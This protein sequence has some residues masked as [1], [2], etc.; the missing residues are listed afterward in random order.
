MSTFDYTSRDYAS[1]QDDL[2]RRAQTLLPE[3]TN[4]EPSDFGMVLVDLWAYMGDILH[5]YVDRAAGESF[6]GTATQRESVL[7]I[8]NLLDYVPSGRRAATAT[9]TLNANATSATDTAP[10]YIP[11]YTRFLAT[12]LVDTASPVVFTTN[13]AIAFTG[14]AGG[15]STPLVDLDGVTYAT[16]PK[17]ESITTFLTEGEIFSETYTSTGLSGQQIT[18]RKTG[19][20]TDGMI[21]TVNEGAGGASVQ[22]TYVPRLLTATSSQRVFSVDISADNY[23]VLNF[24][25]A[26][27]GRIPLVNSTI[28]ITY[29]RSRG[30]AG[31]VASQAINRIESNT[32][33]GKPS[34]DGLVVT[35]NTLAATGGVD[36]ESINSLKANI[37]AAFRSQDRAVSL[38]DY[39]DIV[40]RVPGV[41]KST[42]W[43]DGSGVVQVRA[44]VPQSNFGA[45]NPII[46]SNAKV[47][48]IDDYLTPREMAFASSNVGASV[49]LSPVKLTANLRVMAGF[50]QEDVQSKVFSALEDL[51]SFDN[52][53]FDVT[54]GLGTVYRTALAIEGVD[55]FTVTNFTTTNGTTV[56]DASGTFIGVTPTAHTL[57]AK[58]ASWTINASGGIVATGG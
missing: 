7:A 44:V 25:N 40:K 31:N 30:A 55:Y 9:I 34:L 47:T 28:T 27:N 45:V 46:L 48:E 4:R 32:V 14:T 42:A 49:S 56:L 26:I 3:W 35:P 52:I 16:Y 10:I 43:V 58:S 5:Y 29:R 1:I 15:A 24:G 19:V 2:L 41:V 38:Q 50:V 22:Y 33:A 37:P 12:P 39:I 21:V 18:L 57:L 36:V 51:F 8:A 20:V 23:S 13:T 11:K 6:L 54:V 17:T 53:D